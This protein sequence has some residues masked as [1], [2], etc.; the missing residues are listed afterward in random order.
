MLN[1]AISKT[2]YLLIKDLIG[3][4]VK[5][6]A[7]DDKGNSAFHYLFQAFTKEEEECKQISNLLL[8]NSIFTFIRLQPQSL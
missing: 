1:L 8:T 4:G 5:V 3:R 6:D 7:R 2:Q